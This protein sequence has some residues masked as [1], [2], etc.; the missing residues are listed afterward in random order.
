MAGSS[1]GAA[2]G[3]G[4]A[5]SLARECALRSSVRGCRNLR[6]LPPSAFVQLAPNPSGVQTPGGGAAPSSPVK[7]SAAGA[8]AAADTAVTTSGGTVGTIQN[9]P[10][11]RGSSTLRLKRLTVK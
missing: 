3:I 9:F 7:S 1:S 11:V 2:R 4:T 6:G 8:L 10:Q 5:S